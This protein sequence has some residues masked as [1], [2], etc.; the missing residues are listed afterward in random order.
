MGSS[1]HPALPEDG[2]KALGVAFVSKLREWV[3]L[4]LLST[5]GAV[6]SSLQT[7]DMR[8]MQAQY[9]GQ[10]DGLEEEIATQ[11]SILA[12]EIPWTEEPNGLQST[13]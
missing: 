9:L 10:E 1:T 12:W 6:S 5:L 8:E 11:S 4:E 13:G 7:Q 2:L 3:G